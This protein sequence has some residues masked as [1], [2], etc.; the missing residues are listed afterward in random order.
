L[1]PP[2]DKKHVY[3]MTSDTGCELFAALIPRRHVESL[4]ASEGIQA[5]R[6][7]A[8][9]LGREDAVISDCMTQ[10]AMASHADRSERVV[11]I[12]ETA[13]RLILRVSQLNG[14]GMPDWHDDSSLFDKRTLLRL[15]SYIDDHLLLAPSVSDMSSIVGVSPSH[16]AKKFRSTTGLSLQ[17]FIN[18]QRVRRSMGMLRDQS[19]PLAH[20]ALELGFSSQSHFTRVFSKLTGITPAKYG[21]GFKRSVVGRGPDQPRNAE[22]QTDRPLPNAIVQVAGAR[23]VAPNVDVGS[24]GPTVVQVTR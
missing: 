22:P 20:V 24:S 16:F 13:R 18:R 1:V 3:A 7:R 6:E 10:L 2:D 5:W 15:T 19:K 9:I 12:D 4:A 14:D 8:P 11:A 17:R 21:K 23:A